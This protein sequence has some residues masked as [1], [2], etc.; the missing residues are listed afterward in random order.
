MKIAQLFILILAFLILSPAK[1]ALL[2][3]PVVGFNASTKAEIEDGDSYSGGV[4][5]GYGG[6]LGYQNFGFQLGVDYLKSS[7]DMDEK[8]LKKNVDTTEWAAFVGFEFP[9]LFR[10]YAGYIFSAMGESKTDAGKLE[11][12]DGTGAKLG[13]GTTF[14]PFIDI[15]FEYRRGTFGKTEI[16]G[17]DQDAETDYSAYLISVSLPFTI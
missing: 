2:I 10:V 3:E 6:R 1:A 9:V 15:N 14:L 11:F 16:G 8:E 17:T 7:I 13:V 5:L 4:G 12:D